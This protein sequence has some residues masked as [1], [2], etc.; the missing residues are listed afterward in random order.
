VPWLLALLVACS[1]ESGGNSSGTGQGGIPAAELPYQPCSAE[2]TVGQFVIELAPGFT[3]VG[4][5][6][7]D[8]VLPSQVPDELGR[9]GE[10]RLLAA[11]QTSCVP[12]CPVATQVCGQEA[13]CVAL[14]RARDV[15]TLTVHGLV[16]PLQIQPNAI[17]RSYSD[18]VQARLPHPGFLPGADLRIN[19]A[20]GDYAPFEL[21][22][23]GVSPLV[24]AE[25]PI[26]IRR[27]QA[28][29]LG[30]QAPTDP[31]PARLHVELNI[32]I[33]GATNSWIECDLPDTG[34]G[35]IPAELIDGLF[36]Q[37]LSG[38]PT[39]TATRRSA[40]SRAIEPGCVEMLVLSELSVGVQVEGVVSC[41]TSAQCP[42]GQTCLD[43]ERRCE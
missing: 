33:H 6:V 38:D 22:G 29:R 41:E 2:T 25:A 13:S 34:V 8:A 43:V 31:G 7:T 39:L 11:T 15:G 40:T 21:R 9:A 16:I 28:T 14:P 20:G 18:P 4:G 1:A 35:E 27:G 12:A 19:S 3:R 5:K 23:W 42:L 30:W 24:L 36:G 26:E 17:T 10:C 37:G 32:N